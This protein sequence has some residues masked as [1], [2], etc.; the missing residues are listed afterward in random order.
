MAKKKAPPRK[1]VTH[2]KQLTS[3]QLTKRWADLYSL[4][5]SQIIHLGAIHQLLIERKVLSSS[6]VDQRIKQLVDTANEG[7]GRI[8]AP[9]KKEDEVERLL[10]LL[11]EHR[12]VIQ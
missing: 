5:T 11:H 1:K 9:D 10:K 8:L 4:V 2:K 6:E 3:E 12:G 7:L